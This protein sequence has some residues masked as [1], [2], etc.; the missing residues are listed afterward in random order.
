M[1]GPLWQFDN[2]APQKLH[3]IRWF[4]SSAVSLFFVY[5]SCCLYCEKGQ[6][7]VYLWKIFFSS[8]ICSNKSTLGKS[9]LKLL[10]SNRNVIIW[11]ETTEDD[12]MEHS[13]PVGGPNRSRCLMSNQI[14][15][16]S[17]RVSFGNFR[18]HVFSSLAWK[19]SHIRLNTSDD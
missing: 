11:S 7:L 3:K 5:W 4:L 16:I 10:V 15:R 1:I 13:G 6:N 2:V 8:P 14:C 12:S 17:N 9:L 18:C 19:M